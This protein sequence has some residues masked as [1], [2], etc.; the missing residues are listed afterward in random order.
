MC[1]GSKRTQLK[2]SLGHEPAAITRPATGAARRYEPPRARSGAAVSY[3]TRDIAEA[4]PVALESSA[5]TAG[6]SLVAIRCVEGA[7]VR[8][9][10]LATERRY[11]FTAA[12]P[13]LEVDAKDAAALLN[14][15]FFR[16]V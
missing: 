10:G 14:T 12:Q 13:V 15:R 4:R 9:Q 11:D 16:R 5:G 8:V 6:G 7:P 2:G 1:C 3:G